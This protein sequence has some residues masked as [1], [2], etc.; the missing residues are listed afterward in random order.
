MSI[1]Q[2]P[3]PKGETVSARVRRLQREAQDAA[4]EHSRELIGALASLEA[5]A[6]EIAI[7]GAPYLPGVVN[8]ARLQ[9]EEAAQRIE[10]LTA[11]MSRAG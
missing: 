1:A 7:Q 2:F 9:A 10:R 4:A 5:I 8:E 11:I 6:Q 3:A